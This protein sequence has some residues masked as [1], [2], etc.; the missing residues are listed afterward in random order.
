MEN[1]KIP[2]T[3]RELEESVQKEQQLQPLLCG[4]WFRLIENSRAIE[5][6]YMCVFNRLCPFDPCGLACVS[7]TAKTCGKGVRGQLL[8]KLDL[9]GGSSVSVVAA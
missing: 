4:P 3:Q 9:I 5:A 6:K 2:H 8:L 1:V 7:V